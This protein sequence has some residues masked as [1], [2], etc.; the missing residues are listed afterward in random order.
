MLRKIQFYMELNFSR[1]EGILTYMSKWAKKRKRKIIIVMGILLSVVIIFIIFSVSDKKPTCFDSVQNGTESG[2]D[3]GGECS[4]VCIDEIRNIVVWWERPFKV[5][6]GV[7]N[8]VAYF[9]NQ[10]LKSG[11][12]ELT[13]EF[14]MY[15]ED[16]ILVSKPR[17][18]KTFI[19]ANKR[20]AIFEPGLTTGDNEAHTA[21]FKVSSVQNWEKTDQSFSYGLFNVGEPVLSQQDTH[22]KLTAPLENKSRYNLTDVPVV[23]I[24]YNSEGNAIATSR[25]YIDTINQ[26]QEEDIYYSWPEPFEEVVSRIEIIPRID[27]FTPIESITR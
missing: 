17:I 18:G 14:R 7:Y 6:H 16:N 1:C 12:Q 24:L 20:S 11:I 2:V 25:T 4:K 22:P 26:G 3:C 5:A 15:D 8:A 27:P 13:Y 21:F 23:V 9:E 10:N 19:E